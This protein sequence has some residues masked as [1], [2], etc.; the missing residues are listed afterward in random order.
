MEVRWHHPDLF[1]DDV[2]R[3]AE[4]RLL[5]LARGHG[6][7]MDVRIVAE[8]GRHRHGG[9]E[10]RI[11]GEARG[12]RIVATRSR[13]DVAVALN[14]ALDVFEREIWRLR[15]RLTQER[16]MHPRQPPELGVI[17]E[18]F[19]E[20]GYGFILT[21]GGDR[22]YFHRNALHGGLSFDDLAEGQRVGLNLEG[23]IEG[24]QATV[25]LPA[26]SGSP[27]P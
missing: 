6:D 18:I 20:K 22:V 17:D 2:R 23:G 12:K 24:P 8:A 4:E 14:E 11:I 9:Q 1:K 16:S 3:L 25:V 13:A 19:S 7:L 21:D 15:H 5:E 27:G 10:V 26:P